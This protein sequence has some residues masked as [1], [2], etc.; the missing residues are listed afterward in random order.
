MPVESLQV[1]RR[2]KGEIKILQQRFIGEDLD[3]EIRERI[4]ETTREIA[5]YFDPEWKPVRIR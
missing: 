3:K 2:L 5:E 1:I 4:A